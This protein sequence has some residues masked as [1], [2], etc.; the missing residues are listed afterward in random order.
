MPGADSRAARDRRLQ[1]LKASMP[2]GI[3]GSFL[4]LEALT[5][6]RDH[7]TAS[8]Y[9]ARLSTD[10]GSEMASAPDPDIY[11]LAQSMRLVQESAVHIFL[12]FAPRDGESEVNQSAVLEI[13][14]L[15][16]LC[17]E[18]SRF[19]PVRSC[20]LLLVEEG[21]EV[22]SPLTGALRSSTCSWEHDFFTDPAATHRTA[23]KFCHNALR[24]QPGWDGS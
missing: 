4:R 13:A 19:S 10:L 11:N 7:L 15:R 12:L 21:V 18:Q 1:R 16:R 6:L 17:S 9:H 3:F 2:I 20:A 5:A 24:R 22:R 23:R 14:E 8:G